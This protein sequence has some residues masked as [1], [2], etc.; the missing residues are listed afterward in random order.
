MKS[1]N[2]LFPVYNE[3]KRLT[4]GIEKTVDYLENYGKAEYVLTIVDNASNDRTEE[5]AGKLCKR[6][7]RVRY[8]RISEKG[9]GAAFRAGVSENTCDIVG[10][11]DVDL[12]TDIRHLSEMYELFCGNEHIDM[13]NASRWSKD[14][15]T[16]GRKAY[17]NVTSLGLVFLLKLVFKMHASDAICGFKFFDRNSLGNLMKDASTE[18]GWFYM[19]ELLLRAEYEGYVIKELPVKWEDDSKNSKVNVV[20][21]VANYLQRIV[22]LKRRLREKNK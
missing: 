10:Y 14:S 19:I 21:V 15:D 20:K 2:I 17:R 7:D 1:L 12:A 13:V 8:I 11:M 4:N 22:L 18:N 6:Y 3:E 16:S 5:I 9:V